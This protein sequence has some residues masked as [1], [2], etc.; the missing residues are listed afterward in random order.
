M[1]K[2]LI[3][4]VLSGSQLGVEIGLAD[5]EYSF[6]S[7]PESDIQFA[8]LSMAPVHGQ[9]R[10]AGGK[11]EI[12][13]TGAALQTASGLVIAAGDGEWREIAQLDRITAGTSVFAVGGAD[14]NWTSLA[15]TP[16]PTVERRGESRPQTQVNLN[17]N[18]LIGGGV[19]AACLLAVFLLTR[20]SGTSPTAEK[21]TASESEELVQTT[22]AKL[23]FESDLDVLLEADGTITV[24]GYVETAT[25]RRAVQNALQ[26]LGLDVRRRIWALEALRTDIAGLITSQEIDITSTLNPDGELVLSGVWLDSEAVAHTVGLLESEVFGLSKI[27][28]N[29]DSADDLLADAT[30]LISK[31]QLNDLV[32]IRLD[33]M[34]IE[35]TGVVPRDKIDNWV[36]FMRAYARQIAPH[37]PLRSFVTLEGTANEA[38]VPVIVGETEGE[39]VA[40]RV[41]PTETVETES[42]DPASL[43]AQT[44]GTAPPVTAPETAGET[45]EAASAAV[46]EPVEVPPEFAAYEAMIDEF[47]SQNPDVVEMLIRTLTNG[48]FSDIDGL[49]NYFAANQGAGAAIPVGE[50]LIESTV[51]DPEA[52]LRVLNSDPAEGGGTTETAEGTVEPVMSAAVDTGA[53]VDRLNDAARLLFD[54]SGEEPRLTDDAAEANPELALVSKEMIELADA[55]SEAV[56]RGETLLP[57][58]EA[59]ATATTAGDRCW[60]ESFITVDSLPTV[61]L[62]MD[63]LSISSN[64]DIESVRPDSRALFMEAALNPGRIR[65]CLTAIGGDYGT[66]LLQNSEFLRETARNDTFAEFLFRNVPTYPL[67]LAGINLEGPRYAQL[68]DGR[69]LREGAAPAADSRLA[70]I[71][72]LGL[73][74]RVADGYRVNLYG[75]S[76]GW[77]VSGM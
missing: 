59:E 37:I 28:E 30:A 29:V 45:A 14:A 69:K 70:V 10:V 38:T 26:E 64:L 60:D 15:N 51:S 20:G 71:G 77:L 76:I 9:L 74:I 4:K 61:L 25:E 33:G 39:E 57:P 36:G 40:G 21:M 2:T 1:S 23:P 62:W 75:D 47:A 58:L 42:T 13:A 48:Q 49:R 7:G 56:A 11:V 31:V 44:D 54:T 52:I 34:L 72:D 63:I 19:I 50:A 67:N 46:P 3:L 18:W 43:F 6:G 8:D 12:R 16:A 53:V 24:S 35:T 65:N 73:L 68:A 27:T 32:L 5:G 66:A 22:L 41:L 55:Q 17:R